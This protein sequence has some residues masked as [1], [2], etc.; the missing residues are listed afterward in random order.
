ML[1]L[2]SYFDLELATSYIRYLNVPLSLQ[3]FFRGTYES[4]GMAVSFS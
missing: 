4:P 1:I 3:T 2:P